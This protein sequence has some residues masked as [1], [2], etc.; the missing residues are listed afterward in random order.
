MR[1]TIITTI[2]AIALVAGAIPA[3]AQG[4][5]DQR[6][7]LSAVHGVPGLP[8]DV[9]VL[10]NGSNAFSFGFGDTVGPIA[11]DPGVYAI[12]IQ[13]QKPTLGN[14]LK[15]EY[16]TILKGEAMIRPGRSFTVVAHLTETGNVAPL[17][18][19]ENEISP[20][21]GLARLQVFHLA[22]APTVDASARVDRDVTSVFELAGLSNGE[23]ATAVDV[24]PGLYN[25]GLLAGGAEVFNTGV[26]EVMSN[27]NLAVY[28]VGVF[29][30][31]FR[32]IYLPLS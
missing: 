14:T 27:D 26:F 30:D 9:R 32:L 1:N 10:I 18:V 21:D 12:E 8:G 17:A 28:A 16:E 19:F 23:Q 3:A 13:A 2:A 25:V 4:F 11:I 5:S 7:Y 22:A 29:P 24:Q 15:A 20:Q 31:S 6:G